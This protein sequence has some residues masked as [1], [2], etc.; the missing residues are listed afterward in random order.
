MLDQHTSI[1]VGEELNLERRNL[2]WEYLHSNFTFMRTITIDLPD[3][4][5]LDSRQ[6]AKFLAA[7]LYEAGKLSLGQ[8]AGMV[9]MSKVALQKSLLIMACHLLI[10]LFKK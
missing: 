8:A 3:H 6:T 5:D 10:I 9:G 1:R 4:T 2:E 7:K